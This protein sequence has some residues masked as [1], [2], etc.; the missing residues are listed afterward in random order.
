MEPIDV[1]HPA[2]GLNGSTLLSPVHAYGVN[3][4]PFEVAEK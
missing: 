2:C 1:A 4:F 3:T